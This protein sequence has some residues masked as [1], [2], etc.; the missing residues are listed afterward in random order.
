[1]TTE[2]LSF[3]IVGHVDHGKSTFI[4]RL[5][6]DTNSLNTDRLEELKAACFAL[7]R[8]LEFSFI[9]DHLQEEREQNVTIDTTQIKF[10]T[11]KRNY[12]IIDAPG[13]KEFLKN[14]LTGAS[15]A[16]A[17]VLLV[18]AHEGIQEQTKRHATLLHL[19]GVRQMMVLLNKMD[20]IE[21]RQERFDQLKTEL[22]QFLKTI[23]IMPAHVIPLVAKDGD[24]CV[25]RSER[26]NWYTG[27][28]FLDALDQFTCKNDTAHK[29]LRYPIQDVYKIAD[30]RILVGRVESGTI[31]Q[32]QEIVF[33]PSQKHTRVA[34]IEVF[35]KTNKKEAAPG[36]SIGITLADPL[37]IERGEIACA[38][39]APPPIAKKIEAHAFWF[40]PHAF[41][42]KD[43][44]R[45]KLATQDV[46][47]QVEK[48][49]RI[50][51]STL[52][53]IEKDATLLHTAEIG[54]FILVPEKPLVLE[55]FD[56]IEE[57]GRFVLEKDGEP[58]AGG[59][60]VSTHGTL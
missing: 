1:M 24:N 51:S 36:E 29:P 8:E 3:V 15:Q 60:V 44:I 43:R 34:S 4:G 7:G 37:F 13:H 14:M 40:S 10:K 52:N 21:F 45:L 18:D 16:E 31:C 28:T 50:D 47:C 33:L 57:L 48:V 32:G 59:I 53:T 54:K 55:P 39:D 22:L 41:E 38:I 25:L 11:D 42:K 19:L 20:L 35:G 17:A 6:H 58:C 49:D 30:K 56:Q 2:D 12:T 5:L 26:M 46:Q 9:T 27:A 23:G